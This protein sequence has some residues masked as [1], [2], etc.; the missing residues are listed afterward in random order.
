MSEA[1]NQESNRLS[2]LSEEFGAVELEVSTEPYWVVL[3]PSSEG[4]DYNPE[5]PLTRQDYESVCSSDD[6]RVASGRLY[7]WLRIAFERE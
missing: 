7:D 4:S 5:L 3:V 6:A 1:L 2:L